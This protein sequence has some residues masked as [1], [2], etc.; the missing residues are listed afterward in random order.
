M[1]EQIR[2]LEDRINALERKIDEKIGDLS[3]IKDSLNQLNLK[4][5]VFI[6]TTNLFM[7]STN[8][9]LKTIGSFGSKEWIKLGFFALL[10]LAILTGNSSLVHKLL[11][12]VAG[13]N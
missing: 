7:A 4:M 6:T 13:V 8:E 10:M 1:D 3:G 2:R 5:E 12:N 9:A 11:E